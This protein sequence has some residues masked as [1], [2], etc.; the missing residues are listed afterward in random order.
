MVFEPDNHG[1]THRD[2][3]SDPI[4]FT[5]WELAPI[6]MV[7][8]YDGDLADVPSYWEVVAEDRVLI[9]AGNLYATGATGGAA[10]AGPLTH[11]GA[12]VSAHAGTAVSAHAGAAV[13][14]HSGTAVANHSNHQHTTSG[15]TV[16]SGLGADAA[17]H[18]DTGNPLSALTHSVTQPSNHTVTQPNDHTVTQP[19]NHTVTQPNQ[20]DAFSILPPYYAAYLLKKVAHPG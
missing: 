5:L 4:G 18:V 6:G 11:S 16:Q 20:H 17:N 14:A 19:S 1:Q 9:G 3:G 13:S 15:L 8:S 10:T 12:A 2:G 7:I